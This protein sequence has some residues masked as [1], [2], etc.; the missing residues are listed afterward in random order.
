MCT[1]GR[2]HLAPIQVPHLVLRC[3]SDTKNSFSS[4]TWT[5]GGTVLGKACSQHFHCTGITGIFQWG[6][7][8]RDGVI[9]EKLAGHSGRS[10]ACI[11]RCCTQACDGAQRERGWHHRSHE[12]GDAEARQPAQGQLC[13]Y[14]CALITG[15]HAH[16]LIPSTLCDLA[17]ARRHVL[18]GKD[19]V[20][21]VLKP[22]RFTCPEMPVPNLQSGLTVECCVWSLQ[23]GTFKQAAGSEDRS[24]IKTL[25]KE[26]NLAVQSIINASLGSLAVSPMAGNPR[27]AFW[28]VFQLPMDPH[29]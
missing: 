26:E 3:I 2:S 18:S 1:P 14:N 8:L 12:Q 20:G 6:R 9:V 29:T 23:S 19:R 27:H 21:T 24:R 10:C 17:C 25:P 13:Q 11:R 22:A 15:C 28:K 4:V 7:T 5:S 16:P